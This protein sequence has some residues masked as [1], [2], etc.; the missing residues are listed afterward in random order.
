MPEMR[1]AQAPDAAAI[2]AIYNHEVLHSTAT[3]DTEP[4]SEAERGAWLAHHRGPRRP[5][6]VIEDHAEVVAWAALSSWSDRCAYARAAEVSVYVHREHR[7]RG[8]GRRL[9]EGLI[10]AGRGAGLGVLLAR[11]CTEGNASLALHRR[12]GFSSIG[13]M[14]R[15]GEKLGRVLDIELLELSLE[16]ENEPVGA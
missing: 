3:F 6:F 8:H 13:V 16:S 7:G 9:L 5:V 4:V 10:Q 1:E 12:V 2:A 11:I 15:V 14:R